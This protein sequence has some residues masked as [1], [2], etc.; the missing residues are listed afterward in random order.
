MNTETP[1]QD[2][3]SE[4]QAL[5]AP[6]PAAGIEAYE[7]ERS[8]ALSSDPRRKA[9]YDAYLRSRRRGA[10]V[11]YLPIKLDIENVSRCNFRCTMCIV[12]DW[13]KGQRAE[14]MSLANF[15]RLID[16]Q[17]GLL[18]IKLQ[19]V[20]EPT[21]QR[22]DFFEMI[23]YARSKHIWVRTTTNASLLHLRDNYKKLIDSDVN[24]VQISIDGATKEVFEGI[25]VGSHFESVL[26]NC[27][28]INAYSRERGVRRTKMWTVVQQGN[29][30]QLGALVEMAAEL[31]FTSQ[32]FSLELI[33]WGV[34][35]WNERN[36]QASAEHELRPES[37]KALI[38]KA[39]ALGVT[40]AFWNATDKY[41]IDKVEHLCPWPFE[42][43]FVSSDLRVVPCCMIGNP[44]VHQIGSK[45]EDG[46]G[47]TA[48]WMSA[49]FS[50]FR[51]A[52][53]DG[54]IPQVCRGCYH[55]GATPWR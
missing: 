1:R 39:S 10:R 19:G 29:H 23:R 22:D 26:R 51:Q 43:A 24:E 6:H 27:K 40:L 12:A 4:F 7:R 20:G 30:L 11:D 3:Q 8:L 13:P 28:L 46:Q 5:P 48:T 15:K 49:D 17:Y 47:F 21:M 2:A 42:R 52:H 35:K 31:G 55:N 37:L 33:G 32:V 16:E 18:E 44:D 45:L 25:R 34:D 9:N 54:R 38:D 14:D 36:A 50:E 41:R 53:L